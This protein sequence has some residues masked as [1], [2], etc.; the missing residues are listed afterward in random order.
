VEFFCVILGDMEFDGTRIGAEGMDKKRIKS[1][2]IR[3]FRPDPCAIK[4][5]E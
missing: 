5:P 4:I 2:A 3:S 1:V